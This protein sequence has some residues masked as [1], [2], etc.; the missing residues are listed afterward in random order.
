MPVA[1]F[2]KLAASLE[3]EVAEE[4]K[5]ARYKTA[6]DQIALGKMASIVEKVILLWHWG[7]IHETIHVK[8]NTGSF[9]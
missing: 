4:G 2:I 8:H 3:V 9:S 7:K 1:S 5:L 6:L